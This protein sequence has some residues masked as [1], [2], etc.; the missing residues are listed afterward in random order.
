MPVPAGESAEDWSWRAEQLLVAWPQESTPEVEWFAGAG[1]A[2]DAGVAGTEPVMLRIGVG[3][4][5]EAWA[6][7]DAERVL[8]DAL[9][10]ETGM[11]TGEVARFLA[12]GKLKE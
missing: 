9:E 11:T 8:D 1:S 7:L 6:D 4:R 12:T 5:D 10:I 3:N 2:A